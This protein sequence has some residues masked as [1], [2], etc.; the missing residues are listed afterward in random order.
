MNRTLQIF[1]ALALVSMFLTAPVM[2]A[3]SE[4]LD[5]GVEVDDEFTYRFVINDPDMNETFDEG[6]N[7]TVETVPSMP[8]DVPIWDD[9]PE[10]QLDIVYTNGTEVG[11]ELLVLLGIMFAGGLFVVPIGNFTHLGLL[12]NDTMFWDENST[13]VNTASEWGAEYSASDEDE[14]MS[15]RTT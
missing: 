15:I 11:L 13:L 9:I 6:V 5:W 4:G 3:S 12:L 8:A 1:L 10:V 2:A 7:V 14:D